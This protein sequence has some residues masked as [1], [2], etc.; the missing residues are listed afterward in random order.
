MARPKTRSSATAAVRRHKAGRHTA[1]D[2]AGIALAYAKA[3]AADRYQRRHCKWVR[4]AAQRHL[5]DLKRQRRRDFGFVWSDWHA[6]DVC[7]LVEK[8]PHVEGVWSHPN[9][10]L[11]PFQ[12]FILACVFGWRRKDNGYRRFTLVYEEVARKNAKSTK[13]A[14]VSIYCLCC[15]GDVGPQILTAAT[16]FDQAKKVF[17]PAKR[18]V[19]KL[20]DLQD[21][22]GLTPWAKSI[23]CSDNGGY[24][25]PIH[26]KSKTQD[27]HNPKLVTM[28]EFHAHEDRGLY[29]VMRSSQGQQI[30]P[31]FWGI[32]TA[33]FNLEGVCFEQRA[34]AIKVLQ[35]EIVADHVFAIVFT[36]DRA[37]DFSPPRKT[38]DNPYDEA[39][40][41]KANPL[42][43]SRDNAAL[44]TYLRSRAVEAM[45]G[46]PGDF[47]TK[48]MN[49]WL[50]AAMAWLSPKHW[51]D[52]ADPRLRIRH[53][54]G[55]DCYLG[56]D[57]SDKDD[58]TAITL[59]ALDADNRLLIKSWF[60][61]PEA[62]L[63]RESQA[64][65]DNI[66][67]YR[68][69]V[70]ARRL[71]VTPGDMVDQRIVKRRIKRL[72]KA[73]GAKRVTFDQ[74]GSQIIASELNEELSSPDKPVAFIMNKTAANV[75]PAAR[76][77]EA[78][79]RAKAALIVHDDN[80]VMNWMAG[81]A[82]VDRRVNGSLLPKKPKAMSRQKIDGVDSMIN[83]V[84]PLVLPDTGDVASIYDRR[85]VVTA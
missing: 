40:W 55:L 46:S 59:A 67:L 45:A 70:R 22:F 57:L 83:A 75:T 28:D 16:T 36:L 37:A 43:A 82:V 80:P 58:V 10:V 50:G 71:I 62:A 64:D 24:M 12:I 25:Q 1:K 52:R 47:L 79:V 6:N 76:D 21:A 49:Q 23:T 32:T 35:R 31:L 27:G 7:D 29:D 66:E 65:R 13:T 81:N 60:F 18:M 74:W 34:F 85:G 41:I 69:W 17:Y 77:I 61:V 3:A 2:Y 84:A 19:E 4:L 33:G 15:E 68:K 14:A 56:V 51:A 11:E 54:K 26:A 8:L 38:D 72:F 42:L 53:F 48:N 73:V 44:L 78:R 63:Q 20:P 39:N 9:I 5:D 30:N